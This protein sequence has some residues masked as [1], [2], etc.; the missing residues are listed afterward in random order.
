MEETGW[1]ERPLHYTH[2]KP[3]SVRALHKVQITQHPHVC[4]EGKRGEEEE[5]EEEEA[6]RRRAEFK[7]KKACSRVD[8]RGHHLSANP[9]LLP[10]GASAIG[11]Q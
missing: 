1:D 9:A 7:T 6:W 2:P 5:E 11:R 3:P 10:R 8:L 4:I